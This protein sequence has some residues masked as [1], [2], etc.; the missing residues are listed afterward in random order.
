MNR[1]L[2]HSQNYTPLWYTYMCHTFCINLFFLVP[3]IMYPIKHEMKK[4][5]FIK[6]V[7]G[8]IAWSK[9]STHALD[10]CKV[11]NLLLYFMIIW[12]KYNEKRLLS[13]IKSICFESM[14]EMM[15]KLNFEIVKSRIFILHCDISYILYRS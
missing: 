14:C 15:I 5:S 11:S 13:V 6:I 9:K 4:G 3:N 7:D 2:L 8:G 1:H 12:I 10:F